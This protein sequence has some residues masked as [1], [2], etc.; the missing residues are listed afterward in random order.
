MPAILTANLD[1]PINS[2]RVLGDSTGEVASSVSGVAEQANPDAQK[3]SYSE[4]TRTL[5]GIIAKLNKFYDEIFA[6]QREEI[7]KLSV[8]IAGKILMRKVQDGDYEIESIVKEALNNAPSHP[9]LT[10]HLN[11]DDLAACRKSQ[12][13][14]GSELAG[15]KFAADTNIGR[16][17]C[18]LESPKGIIKSL[19]DEHLEQITKALKKA[20]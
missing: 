5:Q 10:I 1:R 2:V 14:D 19:I 8:E 9:D 13:N 18:V 20:D 6:G 7:A 15:I 4:A 3:N 16:A 17:E 11:P 12:D